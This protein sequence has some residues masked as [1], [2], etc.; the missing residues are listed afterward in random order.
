MHR[1]A[2]LS[3]AL[4]VVAA[5]E[6][7]TWPALQPPPTAAAPVPP[8]APPPALNL[9]VDLR[10]DYTLTVQ[11]GGGCEEVPAELRTR[12]YAARISYARSFGSSDWFLADLSGEKLH[13]DQAPVWME[14]LA[15]SVALDLSDNVILE[16]PSPGAYFATAGYGM[17][18]VQPGELS[19]IS[20]SFR[21]YF[22][23]CAATSGA[24][25]ADRCPVVTMTQDMCKAENSR[26][27]LTRR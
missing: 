21:G 8:P 3:V 20:G 2:F 19:T 4:L 25:L 12:S 5:C 6:S 22:K 15:N 9:V 13:V 24:G 7:P 17:A 14:A 1:T 18:A 11:V 10:G 26:W 16:E 27:T 23:Y